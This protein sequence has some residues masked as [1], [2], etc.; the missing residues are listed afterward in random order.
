MI[1]ICFNFPEL[2]HY[3]EMANIMIVGKEKAPVI[4]KGYS[5]GYP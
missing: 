3:L 5:F 1:F 4:K 2:N